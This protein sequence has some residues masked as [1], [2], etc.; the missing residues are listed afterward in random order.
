MTRSRIRRSLT[1]ATGLFFASIIGTASGEEPAE[2]AAEVPAPVGDEMIVCGQ[3]FKVGAPVV[4]WKD[5]GGYDAY[6]LD[7]R[8]PDPA[9][10]DAP[11]KVEPGFGFRKAAKLSAADLDQVQKDGWDLPTLQQAVDQFV[12]HYDVAGTSRRCFRVLHDE[13]TLSVHFML[14][15]DGTLYQT[16]DLQENA[17]HAT[18]ANSRSIG[19]EI[20]NMGAYPRSEAAKALGAWYKPGPDGKTI[21]TIPGSP[22]SIGLRDTAIPLAPSR[23]E[24]VAGKIHGQELVQ[25]DLTPQQ[26]ESLT[27]LT[28]ALSRTFPK[29]K[30]DAPRDASG[31]VLTRVLT[32]EE[33]DAYQGVLGHFHV[34]TNKTDPGPAF[35]W[36]TAL[37]RDSAP[38]GVPSR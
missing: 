12:V 3:R 23:D 9:K 35:R 27:K 25:Y 38:T 32:P 31:A 4:T 26:Y 20:A 1:I 37:G 19:I 2:V 29:L 15:L 17:W 22:A 6:S 21:L 28:A 36:E 18:K 7:R 5:P 16:L 24:M 8:F 13:R 30:R 11:A 34:Q 10:P 33:F 14:D